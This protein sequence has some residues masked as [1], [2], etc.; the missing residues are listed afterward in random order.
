MESAACPG[1]SCRIGCNE[2]EVLVSAVCVGEGA[3]ATLSREPSGKWS[4]QCAAP[5][6]G[7]AG[8]CMQRQ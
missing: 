7:I 4:A 6:T 5:S 2:G 1:E 3:R 8:A